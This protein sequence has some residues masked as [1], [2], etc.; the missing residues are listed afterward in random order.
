MLQR[1]RAHYKDERIS[2]WD[3]FN[4]VYAVLHHRAYRAQFAQNLQRDIPRVPF[5]DDFRQL[6]DVGGKLVDLHLNYETADPFPLE[7]RESSHAPLS[8]RVN[9]RMR[10]DRA[11]RAIVV[12]ES[13]RLVGIPEEAFEY[14]LGTRTALEWIIDQYQYEEDAETGSIADPNDSDD[15]ESVVKLIERVTTVS[16]ATAALVKSLPPL[17]LD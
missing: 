6:A 5:A 10:L 15:D 14:V 1:V 2:K 11:N 17:P 7:W 4:Y 16:V 3:I 9:E 13:L 8:S 12:N